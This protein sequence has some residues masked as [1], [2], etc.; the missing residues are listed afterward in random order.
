[1]APPGEIVKPQPDTLPA[2]F[3]EWD[4]G[5]DPSLA[6]QAAS[7]RSVEA[8]RAPS[9][10]PRQAPKPAAPR[11]AVQRASVAP[12]VRV[13]EAYQPSQREAESKGKGGKMGIFAAIGVVVVLIVLGVLYFAKSKSQP[14]VAKQP[15]AQQQ[16]ASNS[17]APVNPAAAVPT[18]AQEG[19]QPTAADVPADQ[20]P[21][22]RPNSA[23]MDNQLKAQSRISSDL[24][25]SGKDA[26]PPSSFSA[27]A[28][29]ANASMGNVFSGQSGPKVKAEAPKKVN[30]SAGVAVGLL[31]Q[32]TAPVYPPIAKAARVSGTVVV[33]ATISTSGQIQN[34]R[35]VSGPT[36]LRQAA[37]DAVR[38]WR[39]R[40]YMLDG[41]PVEVE[42]SVNVI[43]ALA[44]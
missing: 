15:V 9:P 38:T 22:N 36:M 25:N 28:L 20:T 10:A 41:Q 11:P 42:T 13:E 26:P 1:M 29:G 23:M 33:Q 24:K 43:F 18:P 12:P 16:T 27:D 34:P 17:S 44:Q 3:A 14:T 32:K 40:P 31:M 39:Y 7:S 30:I 37:V 35:A 5:V 19:T 6:A 4:G 8:P 21:T 2:D